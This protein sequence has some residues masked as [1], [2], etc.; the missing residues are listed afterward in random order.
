MQPHTRHQRTVSRPQRS[1]PITQLSET[2]LKRHDG[3]PILPDNAYAESLVRSEAAQAYE[4]AMAVRPCRYNEGSFMSAKPG[5]LDSETSDSELARLSNLYRPAAPSSMTPLQRFM[6][7]SS[8]NDPN[9]WESRR[10][11]GG[12]GLTEGSLETLRSRA[13]AAVSLVDG[14]ATPKDSSVA[15]AAIARST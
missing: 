14:S 9:P 3:V 13:E 15:D 12:V 8:T 6:V 5:G 10:A 11:M 7:L 4:R 1:R 2:A